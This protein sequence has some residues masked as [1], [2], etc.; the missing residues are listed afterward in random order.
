MTMNEA[1]ADLG[2][3]GLAVMGQNLV[4][5]MADNG[6]TV[7]VYNRTPQRTEEFL[8]GPAADSTIIGTDSLEQLVSQL[9]RPRR[10]MLMVQAGAPVDAVIDSLVPLLEPGDIIIDGGNSHYPDTDRRLEELAKHGIRFVGAGISGGEEGARTGPSIM[11]GGDEAAWPHL[12]DIFEAIAARV[13]GVPCVRWLGPGGSGHY[14]KMVHNGIEY[15]DMQLIAETYHLMSDLLGLSH[16]RMS[17][18]FSDWNQERLESYLIEITSDI[19]A[20][21]DEDGEPLVEKILDKAGQKGTGR[22]TVS[23][24]LE[25]GAPLTLVAEAVFARFLSALKESRTEAARHLLGPEQPVTVDT[26]EYLVSLEE[27]LYSAKV[28]SYAQG[29]QLLAAASRE[30]GWNLDLAGIALI[31]RGGC[32]IRSAFLND[33]ARAF[34]QQPA[35]DNMLLDPFFRDAL[36]RDQGGWREI[37]SAAVRAGVPV[38]ALSSALSFFDG[39]RSKRLPANLIQ[40]QRDYF[41]AH[42]F[43]RIDREPGEHFHVNWSGTGGEVSSTIWD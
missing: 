13:D 4:L 23:N 14:V 41:G 18:V 17:A 28:V 26:D 27:A 5:N 8:A 31:W 9:K 12:Q 42:T 40:A 25:H 30:Y 15:G 34:E 6:Y 7:A 11:P 33:I 3:I 38:P 16:E 10:V 21:R 36:N 43:E 37:V 32:I 35:P 2:L 39:I 20:Y 1:T 24:A 22:W 29:Y 19:L